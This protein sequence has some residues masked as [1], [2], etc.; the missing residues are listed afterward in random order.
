MAKTRE[1]LETPQ[2]TIGAQELLSIGNCSKSGFLRK[3]G[4]LE[5]FFKFIRW[6]QRFV[7]LSRGCI[8]I[9]KNEFASR[10]QVALNL[11][12][13]ERTMR[14]SEG[15]MRWTFEMVPADPQTQQVIWFAGLSDRERKEW[16]ISIKD[17]MMKAHHR[18]E[19]LRGIKRDEYV[20][21]EEPIQRAKAA[22]PENP[23]PEDDDPGG[24]QDYSVIDDAILDTKPLELPTSNGVKAKPKPLISP[25]PK[26]HSS[27][28]S[29]SL[30]SPTSPT[31]D[32]ITKKPMPSPQPARSKTLP[33]SM[34][35]LTRQAFE[36]NGT[37]R[38]EIEE[39]LTVRPE[40]TFLVRK[41][42]QD[43]KEVLS[44]NIEGVLKEFKIYDKDSKYTI[45]HVDFF[46]SL[47]KL[48]EY[49]CENPLP[50]KVAK[51]YRAYSVADPRYINR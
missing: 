14:G 18:Q 38:D 51:L 13:F 23:E 41:S 3:E 22:P 1:V 24:E 36:Y 27:P 5:R 48:L 46:D 34:A 11:R 8:Y 29:N 30:P 2:L 20:Y 42:R 31:V 25:K 40:G 32:K 26:P 49:Y 43:R 10:P 35:S 6:R 45:D 39:I 7:V 28:K 4:T 47:E 12:A 17:E 33:P 21:L 9:F 16:M 37:D 19:D 44:V 50:K 15:R